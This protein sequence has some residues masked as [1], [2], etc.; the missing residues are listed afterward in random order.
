MRCY[1]LRKRRILFCGNGNSA[2]ILK[3]LN[4]DYE[5]YMIAEFK[6]DIGMQYITKFVRADP[7][8][9]K[10]AL[11]AACYLYEK[12]YEFEAVFSLCIDTAISVSIIAEH[13]NLFGIPYEVA[14]NSTI[15][16][17]RSKIF[18]ENNIP[19]PKYRIVN[20]YA[21]LLERAI[22]VE[23][24]L[25]LKPINLYGS[26][27][28]VLVESKQDLYEAYKYCTNATNEK[29]VIVNEYL[30]GTEYSSE[31]LMIDG[32]FHLTGL[33]ERVFHYEKYKPHFVE[34]GDI[35]PTL[36]ADQEKRMCSKVT[37][38]AALAL[39]IKN[40]IVKGDLI[41]HNKQIKVL[42][43]TPRL[44]GPRFGTE[45]IP[46]SNGTNILRAAIQ[47]ALHE[48]ID[49]NYLNPKYEKGMV[50][51]TIFAQPG[52][53]TNIEGLEEIKN[54]PGYYDF[55]WWKF[56]PY[57]VGDIVKK[58]RNMAEGIGYI[59]V[60]GKDRKEA[61]KN[62]NLIEQTIRIITTKNEVLK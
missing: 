6:H 21:E 23:F 42:E 28:V 47:Q 38:E 8:D 9:P 36:L 11:E 62:A 49:Y 40:G 59:I 46:L 10:S 4:K 31:G 37:E 12:G 5:I 17:N 32:K 44:G 22:D 7:I 48:E 53:I 39:G 54:L 56:P 34:V 58:P 52:I 2:E 41:L 50:N 13:F 19:S 27:G 25:V 1:K 29:S 57:S 43:I 55:K 60:T 18:E 3:D 51:R 16:S 15:K 14:V 61:S 33:S 35:I 24:P 30:K 45:M 26:I 20:S